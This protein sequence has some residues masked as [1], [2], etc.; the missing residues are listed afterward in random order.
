ML[1][2]S[3]KQKSME[4]EL[5]RPCNFG[6]HV[7]SCDMQASIAHLIYIFATAGLDVLIYT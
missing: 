7:A 4:T 3:N 2:S 6:R 5:M 1:C